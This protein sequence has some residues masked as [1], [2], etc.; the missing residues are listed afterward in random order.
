MNLF[1]PSRYDEI[2]HRLALGIEPFD[3]QH[4]ARLRYQLQAV[5]DDGQL[6]GPPLERHN[7][8]L[9]ALRY[10]KGVKT[11]LDL[12]FFDA[13]ERSYHPRHDRRRI[14]PRRLRIPLLTLSD[15]ETQE[16]ADQKGF[17]RRLRRPFFFPGAAYGFAA[18]TTALRGTVLRDDK[19]LR[20][21][22]VEARIPGKAPVVG[23][24]HGD[25]RGEFLLL[26]AIR[27]AEFKALGLEPVL[28]GAQ[29]NKPHDVVL[30]VKIFGPTVPPVPTPIDLPTRDALWDLPL[31]TLSPP[32]EDD[33]VAA[34]ISLPSGYAELASPLVNFTIGQGSETTFV[35]A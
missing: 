13:M 30:E 18:T 16:Q 8:N 9:F 33:P 5:Y 6:S 27:A 1:L 10:Q 31:E 26:I 24:A 4:E 14:V 34:G 32:G 11:S 7:S 12:R 28:I 15:V 22:R 25:E 35:I 17:A 19:P 2:V 3:A 29:E 20:W 21:V 23:R